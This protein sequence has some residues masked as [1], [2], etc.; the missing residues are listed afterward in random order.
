MNYS[1]K[2]LASDSKICVVDCL[3][4]NLEKD[5][6]WSVNLLF[7]FQEVAYKSKLML[8]TQITLNV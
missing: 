4:K 8:N 7:Y 5:F 3:S 6:S 1:S 2:N